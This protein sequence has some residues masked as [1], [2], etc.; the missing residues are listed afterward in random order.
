MTPWLQRSLKASMKIN[1]P[2]CYV[3]P[4]AAAAL[5][6]MTLLTGCAV[7][8]D[9]VRPPLSLPDQ[10]TRLPIEGEPRTGKKPEI[11]VQI[12]AQQLSATLDIPA[13]W[14]ETF[15]SKPLNA[16][17]DASLR[18]NPS[19]DAA[20]AALRAAR[21]NALVMSAE[22]WPTVALNYSPTR[23]L[24]PDALASPASSNDRIYNL[25]TA[26]VTVAYAP[27]VFGGI[28]RAVETARAQTEQQRFQ[29]EATYLTLSSNVVMAAISEA[30]LRAQRTATLAIVMHQREV[31]QSYV[32]QQSLGQAA[33]ADIDVQRAALATTEAMVPPL[34]KQLAVQRNLLATLAGRYPSDDVDIHFEL[35]DLQLPGEL[36]LALPST[37]VAHRPDV[38]AA[39]EQLHAASA[40]IGVAVAARLPNVQLGTSAYGTSASSFAQLFSASSMFWTLAASV[41]QPI[42]DGGALKHREG[43]ARANFDQIAAQY[44]GTVLG[45]FQ[46]VANA[47]QAIDADTR[48]LR[49]AVDAEHAT[50]RS[51]ERVRKQFQLGDSSALSVRVAEQAWQQAVLSLVQAR[52]ARLT[53]TA[54]LF[55]ALGGGW[56]N[57]PQTLAAVLP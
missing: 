39:E 2:A 24:V 38:R 41:T 16:W 10:Y 49:T 28:R 25:H 36:P 1:P 40:G 43:V 45:A 20:Q 12:P 6:A 22:F 53:D 30:S 3:Q 37:L 47:L 52:A 4:I 7:G 15:H 44:R 8:P 14:W 5:I 46:D 51:L 19:V 34:D 56:W 33:M 29:L 17:V 42:I 11:P 27:D 55:Q 35:D 57:R 54:A 9:Y 50:L 26:Q 23:Q 48:G 31:L 13:Q 21:E 18:H 32:R